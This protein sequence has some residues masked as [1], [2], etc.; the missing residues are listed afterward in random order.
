MLLKDL[1]EKHLKEEEI[2]KLLDNEEKF[3]IQKA[4]KC[5][6]KMLETGMFK[7]SWRKIPEC[8]NIMGDLSAVISE[9]IDNF[10]MPTFER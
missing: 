10:C 1:Y 3:M 4:Q 6:D 7:T 9:T 5:I 2:Q 8:T